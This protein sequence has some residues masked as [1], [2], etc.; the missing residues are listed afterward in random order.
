MAL[1]P[2]TRAWLIVL[3]GLLITAAGAGM[4]YP[5]AGVIL[6]GAAVAAVGL[7]ALDVD[8]DGET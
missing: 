7:L 2:K 8:R 6:A 5:P 3:A 4:I 1:T